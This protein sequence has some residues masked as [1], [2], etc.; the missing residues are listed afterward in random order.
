MTFNFTPRIVVTDHGV[1]Q[2]PSM[3]FE[4]FL[5]TSMLVAALLC[6]WFAMISLVSLWFNL[7][8]IFLMAAVRTSI[9]RRYGKLG[10]PRVALDADTLLVGHR[11]NAPA[12]LRIALPEM[13]ELVIYGL[14]S[15]RRYRFARRDGTALE[16]EPMW[17]RPVDEAVA[18]FLE[19]RL[20]PAIKLT[21]ELPQ[22]FFAS[23]RGDGPESDTGR[24]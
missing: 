13:Q 7:V 10:R 8:A 22:T 9:Y 4:F 6:Y 12:V 21:V 18:G 16:F 19:A 2:P 17:E 5:A 14:S 23:V 11:R 1:Y 3:V 24:P 15:R 20:P